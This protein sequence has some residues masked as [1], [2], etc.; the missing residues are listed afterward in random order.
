MPLIKGAMKINLYKINIICLIIGCVDL[1]SALIVIKV[2]N[3]LQDFLGKFNIFSPLLGWFSCLY[4]PLLPIMFLILLISFL[5]MIYC[6]KK[7]IRHES[8]MINKKV[9]L[10]SSVSVFI[11]LLDILSYLVVAYLGATMAKF[12]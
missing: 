10:L 2:G 1:L 9:L 3:A 12:K 4:L 11:C 7:T 5:T 6:L 8:D